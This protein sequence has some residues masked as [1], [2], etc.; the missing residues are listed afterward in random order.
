MIN[1]I[2]LIE[3]YILKLDKN[4]IIKDIY[5]ND[6]SDIN[7]K[8][9]VV[10]IYIRN[11]HNNYLGTEQ[12]KITYHS[13]NDRLRI[14]PFNSVYYDNKKD[15]LFVFIYKNRNKIKNEIKNIIKNDI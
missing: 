10:F 13:K 11:K 3:N 15:C 4:K 1:N 6:I 12:I 7:N 5:A 8:N 14:S 2:R 9:Y